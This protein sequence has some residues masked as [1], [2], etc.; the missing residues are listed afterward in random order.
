VLSAG[1]CSTWKNACGRFIGVVK[2]IQPELL[3]VLVTLAADHVVR[4]L[5]TR[6]CDSAVAFCAATTTF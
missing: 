1:Y 3:V 6:S 2:M 5:E 4:L